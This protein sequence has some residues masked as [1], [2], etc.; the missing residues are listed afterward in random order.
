MKEC[1]K[2]K[3]IEAVIISNLPYKHIDYLGV[4]GYIAVTMN[5]FMDE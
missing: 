5:E 2:G 3:S 4:S 1:L